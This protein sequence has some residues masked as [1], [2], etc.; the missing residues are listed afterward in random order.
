MS[1][2][3]QITKPQ[4]KIPV[5]EVFGP[6]IQG[7]GIVCGQQTY[8]IRFGLC[9][10]KCT[11]C[12]SMHAV[13]PER[14]HKNAQWLTQDEIADKLIEYARSGCSV[15]EETTRWVTFTGGNP[16]IHDLRHLCQRLIANG[17]FIAVETQGTFFPQWLYHAEVLTVSPKG[18]GMGETLDEDQ[19]QAFLMYAASHRNVCFKYVIFNRT[20]HED[21][22]FI[23]GQ[24]QILAEY[25]L[26]RQMILSQGNPWP[27]GKDLNL[28]TDMLRESL[29]DHYLT[30]FEAIRKNPWLSGMKFLPQLHVWLWG[31]KQGV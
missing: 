28:S 29:I 30:T 16:A 20:L 14:V 12:D 3:D 26:E 18:P 6:T 7:E 10:Y 4:K 15:T 8:F 1:L 9:D 22:A 11:M 21:I 19:F 27:P 23:R 13:D 25:G 31:N 2:Q 5:M 17:W 24:Y